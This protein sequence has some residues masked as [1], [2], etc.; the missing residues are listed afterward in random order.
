MAEKRGDIMA[1]IE[2]RGEFT[3]KN[4]KEL[5]TKV[6]FFEEKEAAAR[7]A[8]TQ[9][10]PD[11]A[12]KFER[13]VALSRKAVGALEGRNDIKSRTL[14]GKFG[15]LTSLR[16]V[17]TTPIASVAL[18]TGAPVKKNETK[19]KK[20]A[21][22]ASSAS[23]V[24]AKPPVQGILKKREAAAFASTPKAATFTP[25]LNAIEELEAENWNSQNENANGPVANANGPVAN[26][27]GSASVLG[28]NNSGYNSNAI[29]ANVSSRYLAKHPLPELYDPYTGR[30]FSPEESPMTP[31]Q[32]AYEELKAI[33][34]KV[35][36][37]VSSRK[38]ALKK[39][40]AAKK[41]TRKNRK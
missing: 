23:S 12:S 6:K 39:K 13:V 2:G 4:V 27:N 25:A 22:S 26:A 9:L 33:R 19:S 38:L 10:K 41:K 18:A 8:G 30:K 32:K 35:K 20:A 16:G 40:A 29:L 7:A 3:D 21:S 28:N 36:K 31:I 5:I 24:V 17:A 15:G 14:L 34:A 37:A 1:N 11:M